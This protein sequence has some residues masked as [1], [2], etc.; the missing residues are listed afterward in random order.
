MPVSF[1]TGRKDVFSR[2]EQD[3]FIFTT[4]GG[5]ALSLAAAIAT[6]SEIKEKNVP[7]Y[8]AAK[9]KLLKDGYNGRA[10]KAGVSDITS[11]SGFDCRS[12]IN[13]NATA[14]DP[15]VLKTLMQQEMIKRGVLW[16]G[17]HNMSFSHTDEDIQCTLDAY[18]EV[19][20][21]LKDAVNSGKPETYLQG[22]VL[23]MV[24]RKTKY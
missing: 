2:G 10:A 22:E 13:F 4:F 7:A 12:I 17:F 6:V 24:F 23:E 9:G 19:F 16:G 8:L 14:G 3:V 1:L 20:L 21:I 11:C 5:E 18:A 15:L